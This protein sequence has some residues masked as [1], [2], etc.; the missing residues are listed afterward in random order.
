ME[1]MLAIS[2][3]SLADSVKS[4]WQDSVVDGKFILN[5]EY[6]ATI[7]FQGKKTP[8]TMW[9]KSGAGPINFKALFQTARGPVFMLFAVSK[10]SVSQKGQVELW[11]R[12]AD[13]Q[14]EM[15]EDF[16]RLTGK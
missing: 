12:P 3:S 8:I 13:V 7:S 5:K 4:A 6:G 1:M 9:K 11:A 14:A 16:E 10:G 2:S 15:I